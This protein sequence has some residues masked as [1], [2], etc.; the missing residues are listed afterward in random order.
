MIIL[1]I[2]TSCDE[3]A[4]AVVKDGSEV[5]ASV[6]ASQ[7]SLHSKYG[8]VVPEIACRAHYEVLLPA[9]F[10]AFEEAGITSD[11]IDAVAVTNGP[12]LIGALLIGLTGAKTLSWVLNRPIVPVNHVEAHL[13]AAPMENPE[14]RYPFVGLVVSGGHT[15]LCHSL[16]ETEM[17]ILGS[18]ID[19][20]AG[21]AFDKVSAILGLGYPGG[22]AIDRVASNGDPAAIRF[23]RSNMSDRPLD[24]SFSGLKTAVL[25]HCQ[26]QNTKRSRAVQMSDAEVADVAASFQEAVV[27]VLVKKTIMA[28]EQTGVESVA[29]GGG[30]AANSRLREKL[31][32]AAEERGIKAFCPS[33]SMCVD[34][35][36]MI[37]GI[38]YH[39][40]KS[41]MASE[42]DV[43]AYARLG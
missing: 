43:D 28:A 13:Y 36:A 11:E 3:T 20:A 26:G 37:A 40:F 25:Y 10:Q 8:G 38:G 24:F 27:D 9:L 19:D 15:L 14:L 7:V 33:L 32:E 6:V 1:G 31:D 41:G 35:A 22:P 18:T 12:G 4:V 30:V 2:E 21:E 29:V 42:L 16:S 17:Q 23:P 39:L 34:N 5:L